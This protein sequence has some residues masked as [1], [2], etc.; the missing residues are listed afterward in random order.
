MMSAEDEISITFTTIHS[1]LYI[2]G[3]YLQIRTFLVCHREQDFTWK[4]YI[5][6]GVVI[7]IYYPSC[8]FMQAAAAHLSHP[9]SDIT[10]G[11]FCHVL[12]FWK[13]LGIVVMNS[14]SLTTSIV[15]YIFV[16][17]R[18]DVDGVGKKKVQEVCFWLTISLQILYTISGITNPNILDNVGHKEYSACFGISKEGKEKGIGDYYFCG[19]EP[20]PPT[21]QFG[22]YIDAMTGCLCVVQTIMSVTISCNLPEGYFYYKIFQS[23]YR[24]TKFTTSMYIIVIIL[25]C[26]IQVICYKIENCFNYFLKGKSLT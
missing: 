16:V 10:G 4:V 22:S 9:L 20:M 8:I 7:L 3:F 19:F 6:H 23:I 26:Y 5:S 21:S 24:Y 11:W 13:L 12:S 14:H 2:I 1:I 17:H 18:E 25:T 15:K